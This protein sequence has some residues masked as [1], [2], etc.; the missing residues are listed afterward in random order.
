M[1]YVACTRAKKRLYLSAALK[2]GDD[3]G[4]WSAP[5]ATSFLGQIYDSISASILPAPHSIDVAHQASA[6]ENRR[7]GAIKALDPASIPPLPALLEQDTPT[8]DNSEYAL[9]EDWLQRQPLAR[10]RGTAMHRILQLLGEHPKQWAQLAQPCPPTW[11]LLLQSMNL[12]RHTASTLAKEIHTVLK[13]LQDDSAFKWLMHAHEESQF[14]WR[15]PISDANSEVLIA[16][17]SFIDGD[18]RWIIDFKSSAPS[19]DQDVEQF[20]HAECEQYRTQLA[21]YARRVAKFDQGKTA[22][23]L[24]CALY[25]PFLARLET[26]EDLTIA[27]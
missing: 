11:T 27:Y 3:E 19:P 12:A 7:S 16:D 22:S 10:A 25:F 2:P 21:R 18:T 9:L 24:R 6:S 4:S 15:L 8:P 17:R 5:P 1:F 20:V 14:E 23:R 26:L 13:Q